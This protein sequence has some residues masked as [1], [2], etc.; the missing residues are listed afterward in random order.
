MHRCFST[1]ESNVFPKLV[2]FD[3]EHGKRVPSSKVATPKQFDRFWERQAA[4]KLQWQVFP[5]SGKQGSASAGNLS[6]FSGGFL[7]AAES[8]LERHDRDQIALIW[9]TD[10]PGQTE[11][12]NYGELNDEVCRLANALKGL[13]VRHG[14]FVA[15]YMPSCPAAVTAML[16]CAR[17]GAVHNVIFAGDEGLRGG[18]TIPLKKTVDEALDFQGCP[19]EHVVVYERTGN[20]VPMQSSRDVLWSQ[21]MKRERPVCPAALVAAEGQP[22]GVVHTTAGYL[23]Q[24]LVGLQYVFDIKL[25]DDPEDFIIVHPLCAQVPSVLFESLPTYPNASRYWQMV[26]D[27]QV[28]HFYTSP[29]AIRTLMGHGTNPLSGMSLD[30]LKVLGTVGEPINPEAWHWQ[31]E[32]GSVL[33]SFVP[34]EGPYKPGSCGKL[35]W[36]LEA[37][38]LDPTTLKPFVDQTPD[39]EGALAIRG[40]TARIDGDGD[41]WIVGRMDDVI[42]K[43]GHRIGSAELENAL[44]TQSEYVV[45][46]AVVA[47]PDEV[48][49]QGIVAFVCLQPMVDPSLE[50]TGALKLAVRKNLSP[51]ATPDLIVFTSALPKTRSGKVMRRLLRKVAEGQC[52][53]DE[54]GDTSTLA[55]P[56]VIPILIDSV[57]QAKDNSRSWKK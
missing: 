54:L 29:T 57:A 5:E 49:G 51:I 10:T 19:V 21:L 52:E 35:L 30:S 20:E 15:I 37:V 22:K 32:T 12:M 24:A 26:D 1:T 8:C 16:A 4:D 40:D 6:Y 36:G 7:N 47:V 28:T 34:G 11:F 25:K 9:E 50:V 27:L 44:S 3:Y 23:L 46:S 48:H 31:T 38:L 14:D 39:Q 41:I 56:D 53:S 13:G 18:K 2:S 43:S 42:N 45:E 17:I 33:C 55:D